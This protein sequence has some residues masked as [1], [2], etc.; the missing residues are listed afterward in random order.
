MIEVRFCN[1]KPPKKRKV[2][3][4]N[5]LKM[6]LDIYIYIYVIMIFGE[7]VRIIMKGKI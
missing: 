2:S 3:F 5:L 6:R 4:V 7:I 1:I